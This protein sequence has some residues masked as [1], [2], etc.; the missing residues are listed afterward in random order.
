MKIRTRITTAVAVIL[1]SVFVSAPAF[2]HEGV[3]KYDPADAF[4]HAGEPLQVYAI[5]ICGAVLL[6]IVLALAHLVG[7]AFDKK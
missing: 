2:A 6:F 4:S 1:A 5:L 3:E 7:K